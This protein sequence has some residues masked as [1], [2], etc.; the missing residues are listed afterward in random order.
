M[1]TQRVGR[2][3]NS[4]DGT[5]IWA[6]DAGNR[7]G[8]PVIFLHALACTSLV[9]DK[10][11]C[12][13]NLLQDLY[14]VRYELRGHG[15]S[16]HPLSSEAYTSQKYAE[17]FKAV[18]ESFGIEKPFVCAW[19]SS[20]FIIVDIVDVY[21]PDQIAGVVYSGGPGISHFLHREIIHDHMKDKFPILR[22][23]DG[24]DLPKAANVFVD[25]CFANPERDLPY[26]N[27][28]QWLAGFLM[29]APT[30]RVNT[31]TRPQSHARWETEFTPYK[32]HLLMHGVEDLHIDVR[33]V[34]PL[35]ERVIP[36][37]E[38]KLLDG[39]GH[40][41]AWEVPEKHNQYLLEFVKRHRDG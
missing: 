4:A 28:L 23:T 8:I 20:A 37:I 35:T 38:V 34:V 25:S 10:Q 16:D 1:S 17:D 31:V 21:G 24:D 12:D 29:Q 14:M 32:P 7:A 18:C 40:A 2:L 39:V 6:D 9:W 27:R 5:R 11:F 22:S 33:K 41:L 19:L 3:V 36:G 30:V 15:Q 26:E 13:A